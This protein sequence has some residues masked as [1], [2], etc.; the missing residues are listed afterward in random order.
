[1]RELQVV[2]II[3]A[4]LIALYG[5]WKRR[6]RRYSRPQYFISLFFAVA[7]LAISIEPSLGDIVAG[8]L[9]ME[10]WN[11]VLFATSVALFIM[12]LYSMNMTNANTRA[13]SRLIKSIA[14]QQFQN[15]QGDRVVG[16]VMVVIPAYN[17]AENI[18][19][20]L[21]RMPSEVEGMT[22]TPLVVVDGAT[23]DT[24]AVA[25]N[26]GATVVENPIQRGGGAAVRVGYEVAQRAGCEI[27]VTMDADGQHL[28][29]EIPQVVRPIL[30]GDADFVNGSRV[31]GSHEAENNVRVAGVYF[32]NWLI[33]ALMFTKVTDASNSFRA[34]RTDVMSGLHLSQ[35]QFY[36]SEVLIEALKNGYRVIEVPI[37]IRARQSG[38]TKKPPTLAYGW[39]FAKAIVLAWLR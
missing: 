14:A 8:P 36:T 4:L 16:E 29:E 22:I 26:W 2:G 34:I 28:P 9:K 32:F 7:L 3:I 20:V 31:L 6:R 25:R 37:T 18:G 15:E 33:S 23:D 13:L 38:E 10:R 17:E 39:G 12:F 35:D 1:M 19:D 27:I 24:A 5:F 21:K 11:A 30:T